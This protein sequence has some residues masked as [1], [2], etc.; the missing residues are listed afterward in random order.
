MFGETMKKVGSAVSIMQRQQLMDA[1]QDINSPNEKCVHELFE[2]QAERTLGAAAVKYENLSLTYEGL[3]RRANQLAHY[4]RQLGAGPDVK[5]AICAERSLEMVVGLL[6]V[7]K[8]GA[9]YVPLDPTYPAARLRFILEDSSPA[10]LMM[11]NPLRH[12][13]TQTS[14]T[15][16]IVDLT[17][18]GLWSGEPATNLGRSRTGLTSRHLA[19][20]I[21]TSGST[22]RPKGVMVEHAGLSNY[23]EWALS[24]YN[25]TSAIVS[26]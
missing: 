12:K 26:S 2:E 8:S 9:A 3:N 4:L 11:Q 7:L 5:V 16:T 25:P 10:V 22:G 6:A 19:Y 18:P 14:V 15:P 21:Y 20:V 24:A 17:N 1:W 13:L 23:L